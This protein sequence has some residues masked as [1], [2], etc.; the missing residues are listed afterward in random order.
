MKRKG[1]LTLLGGIC[2]VTVL[3]VLPFLGA[4]AQPAPA[5]TPAPAPP[6]KPEPITLKAL[7][8]LP[9]KL[10]TVADFPEFA[11]RV[12]ERA[13]GELVIDHLGGPDCQRNR[14]RVR[15]LVLL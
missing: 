1:L 9:G 15:G 3:A 2:L 11:K 14:T 13:K 10:P 5:P 6:P 7:T 12:N 4:C 8:F